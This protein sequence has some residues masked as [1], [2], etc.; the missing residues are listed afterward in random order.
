M[1]FSL[2]EPHIPEE[3]GFT[4]ENDIFMYREFGERLANL[5]S[6]ISNPLVVTLDGLWGS[7]KSVFIKQW[8]GLMRERGGSV[9]YFDVF[10]NDIHDNAFLALA[11]EIHF[12]AEDTLGKENQSTQTFLDKATKVAKTLAPTRFRLAAH[13]GTGGLYIPNILKRWRTP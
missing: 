9:V 3:G 6:N 8:A 12:L 4:T 10:G 13:I 5:V 1:R 11:S 7:G 2:P